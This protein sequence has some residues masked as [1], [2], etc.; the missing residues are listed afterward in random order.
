MKRDNTTLASENN[1]LRT[2]LSEADPGLEEQV[3]ETQEQPSDIL[4]PESKLRSL[5]ILKDEALEL[6][7]F[8]INWLEQN[9][10]NE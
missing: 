2:L 7:E 4:L 10:E 6:K 3:A 8:Y 5:L 1:Q 9:L